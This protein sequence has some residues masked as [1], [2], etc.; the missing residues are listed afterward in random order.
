M[1]LW[2][3]F[4]FCALIIFYA[5]AKLSKYG[6]I[7]AEKTGLGRTWVG[8][9][10][11]AS[12]TSF[13]EL[14]TGISSVTYARTPDIALGNILGACAFNLLLFA[15]LDALH[16]AK[17]ISST[18]S[19]SHILSAGFGIILLTFVGAGILLKDVIIK[20]GWISISSFFFI[21][22]YLIAMR[23]IYSHEKKQIFFNQ[24]DIKQNLS[25]P[26]ASL[27]N[28][29][30]KFSINGLAVIIAAVFLPKIG[31]DIAVKT[32]LGETFVGNFFIAITTTLP[33][34]VVS[35][36]ALRIGATDLALGNIFGSNLFNIFI[37]A[38][39]DLLFIKG[40]LF[41]FVNPVH[42]FP[43]LTVTA[44][45]AV[46]IIGLIYKTEKKQLFLGRDS[47]VI[48]LLYLCNLALLYIL[49]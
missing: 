17:P 5:G 28:V 18:A 39:D 16:P 34:M 8:V 26:D 14:V 4:L 20:I 31:K 12:V 2:T 43:V 30:L 38:V 42:I 48:I 25:Y 44:M 6:D 32:G 49:K 29:I 40:P 37:L 22:I 11:I 46:A 10:L 1:I 9:V 21:A 24:K 36:S 47:I 15:L 7:I 33:E 27:K 23:M 3:G 19:Q 13:P 45:T 41:S 35:I